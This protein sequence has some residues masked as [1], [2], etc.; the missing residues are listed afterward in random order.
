MTSHDTSHDA[1]ERSR[2]TRRTALKNAAV[3][4]GVV[5]VAPV[6]QVISM[7]SAA[8]ASAPPSRVQSGGTS[9][10]LTDAGS[11]PVASGQR[12]SAAPASTLPR[13]GVDGSTTNLAV[14]GAGAIAVGGAA[15]AM[16]KR[17]RAG[18]VDGAT[19]GEHPDALS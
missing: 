15:V 4:A 12:E 10:P 18:Q 2:L 8:A 9:R 1:G 17:R 13:T 14:I 3:A 16:A 7:E 11:P 6:I 5:W 19:L